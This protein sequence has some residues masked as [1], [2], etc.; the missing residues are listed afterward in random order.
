MKAN[1]KITFTV[2]DCLREI[3]AR[4]S[5]AAGIAKAGLACAESGQEGEASRIALGVEP[6]ICEA[7]NFLS[8][9]ALMSR[10]HRRMRL[11]T[12]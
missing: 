12:Y 6:L 3:E 9:A 11:E 7:N 8:M 2:T 5:E 4:L 1:E 10:T